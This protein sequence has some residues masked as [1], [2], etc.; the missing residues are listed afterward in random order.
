MQA[1][2]RACS[3]R[4]REGRKALGSARV[5]VR[6]KQNSCGKLGPLYATDN[7]KLSAPALLASSCLTHTLCISLHYYA[8][9]RS[10]SVGIHAIIVWN[11]TFEVLSLESS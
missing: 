3:A 6:I 11:R 10:I 1:E 7:R 2:G 8:A 9:W 4:E 5:L